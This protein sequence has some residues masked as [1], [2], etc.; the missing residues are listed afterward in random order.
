MNSD[1]IFDQWLQSKRCRT[2][3]DDFADTLL[4][5]ITAREGRIKIPALSAELIL[6]WISSR[7]PLKTAVVTAG[8]FGSAFRIGVIIYILLCV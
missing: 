2:A 4:H 7:L 1:E 8:G 3:P 5:K 6:E